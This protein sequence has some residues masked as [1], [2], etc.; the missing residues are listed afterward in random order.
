MAISPPDTCARDIVGKPVT[1]KV[2]MFFA[3][4]PDVAESEVAFYQVWVVFVFTY[5]A[6]K[7]S[8]KA[9]RQVDDPGMVLPRF[10]ILKAV[11]N[12]VGSIVGLAALVSISFQLAITPNAPLD[13]CFAS[14]IENRIPGILTRI[15]DK[16]KA[17]T[18]KFIARGWTELTD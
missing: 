8:R 13:F 6:A 5:G 1:S 17:F 12:Q 10:F 3:L 15:H 14:E 9:L 16:H 7:K 4:F 18:G 11:G 2:S